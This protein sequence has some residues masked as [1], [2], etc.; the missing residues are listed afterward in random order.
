M[1]HVLIKLTKRWYARGLF[2]DKAS[3]RS[4]ME[5]KINTRSLAN[6]SAHKASTWRWCYV[7][8]T[9][10]WECPVLLKI[11]C[12]QRSSINSREASGAAAP[13]S[14]VLTSSSDPQAALQSL[15]GPKLT[16]CTLLN[17]N[18]CINRAFTM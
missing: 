5:S 9:A 2:P 14:L 4:T 3:E 12:L 13:E 17:F 8:T 1:F 18:Y 10:R 7:A 15:A 16:L 11:K 6:R